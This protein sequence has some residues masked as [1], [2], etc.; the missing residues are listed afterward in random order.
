MTTNIV[1]ASGARG[2]AVESLQFGLGVRVDGIFGRVTASALTN[3]QR[4][5]N[6]APTGSCTE[7]QY[8]AI[9]GREPPDRFE[10]C[11]SVTA[12]FEQH[13]WA[14]PKILRG[15]NWITAGL[16]GFTTK[17][18]SLNEVFE[19]AGFDPK[20]LTV[21][22]GPNGGAILPRAQAEAIA[23][24]MVTPAG[25]AAQIEVARRRYWRDAMGMVDLYG[26]RSPWS[27]ALC[28][29]I[30]VQNGPYR[31]DLPIVKES[32]R[33]ELLAQAVIRRS[34]PEW[35]DN[36]LARKLTLAYGKGRANDVTI[37]LP[38]F[39]LHEAA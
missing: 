34:K 14:T 1:L 30:A 28:F 2:M 5:R 18:Q 23:A 26:F 35:R 8:R 37:E 3:W 17:Y 24:L 19:L 4:A 15:E 31:A 33:R 12:A 16:I 25:K 22:T 36:V 11:L 29:D 21:A 32:T 6:E 38:A 13:G 27:Y 39:G 9:A 10:R 20:L 7:Q